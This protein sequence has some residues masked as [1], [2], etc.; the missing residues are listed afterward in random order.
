MIDDWTT[1]GIIPEEEIFED[2]DG[3]LPIDT[4][5][6]DNIIEDTFNA[7]PLIGISR[8]RLLTDGEGVT[9]LV[10][11]HGCP[12]HCKYCINPECNIVK[13]IKETLTP[14]EL[15]EKVKIDDIYFLVTG[16]GIMFGGGEPLL[17]SDFIAEFRQICGYKWKIYIETS[18]NVSQILI[19]PLVDIIDYWIIDI[20]DWN[21]YIY[22]QYTGCSNSQVKENLEYL[23]SRGCVDKIMVRVPSIPEYNCDSDI[24]LTVEELNRLGIKSIDKFEYVKD[25]K[26]IHRKNLD[27]SKDKINS[28]KFKC[29][30][31]KS[32]RLHVAE[33]NGIQ[34]IPHACEHKVCAT[35]CCPM[36]DKELAWVTKEYYKQ[37]KL[38]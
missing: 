31:L 21:D 13:G 32:I 26:S 36:C 15:Y 10:A 19:E 17:R 4:E 20:K 27:T 37:N 34:Y 30:V 29:E 11:F 2:L 12:L 33:Y 8:H 7:V 3:M 28:G 16:G 18:L 22:T 35:G 25:V 14:K 5:F 23:L 1:S 24:K 6:S 38:I 9:T